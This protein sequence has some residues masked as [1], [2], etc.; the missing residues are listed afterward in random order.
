MEKVFSV[1]DGEIVIVD[2]DVYRVM[3]KGKLISSGE[4]LTIN[5]LYE[6]LI[7]T[8]KSREI[9]EL[10]FILYYNKDT[11]SYCI[12]KPTAYFNPTTGNWA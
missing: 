1:K 3:S 5:E 10:K 2:G 12:F 6:R 4:L 7:L 8:E 9:E 11:K